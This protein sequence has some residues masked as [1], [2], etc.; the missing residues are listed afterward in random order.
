MK[1]KSP[2]KR[3]D[4]LLVE[5][6]LAGSLTKARALILA[7]EIRIDGHPARKAG[8][9]VSESSNVEVAH[10]QKYASRA[11]TKLEG[12]LKDFAI[13]P[14]DKICMDI[15][16]STGG[17]TDCLLQSGAKKVFAVDVNTDQLTWKL[18]KH[19][20]VIPI[21]KNARDLKPIDLPEQT[22]IDLAVADVSFISATKILQA[23]TNLLKPNADFLIL[24]KPQFELPRADIKKGGIV[25]DPAL[26]EKAVEKVRGALR[27][28]QLEFQAVRASQLPGAEGNQEYFLHTRKIPME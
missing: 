4:E 25:I 13:D 12:A 9:V 7:G 21:K 28:A 8:D 3:L 10:Q 5:R 16:S 23:V 26:H 27:A 15:G 17:F 11:G 24:V 22:P 2:R 18:Q 14:T 6:N 1:R 20:N 19:P